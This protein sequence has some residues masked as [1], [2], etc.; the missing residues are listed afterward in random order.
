MITVLGYL[1]D[2]T[3]IRE[4]GMQKYPKKERGAHHPQLEI[5]L[6]KWVPGE[7]SKGLIVTHSDIRHKALEL[8]H[9]EDL[10]NFKASDWWIRN[11]K[12]RNRLTYRKPTHVSRKTHFSAEDEVNSS[13]I[14]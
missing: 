11:F 3:K 1:S 6:H 7:G 14:G 8:A 12:K 9:R 13:L 4:E 10:V 2:Y 5:E